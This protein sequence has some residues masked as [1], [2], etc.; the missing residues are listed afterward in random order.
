MALRLIELFLKRPEEIDRRIASRQDLPNLVPRL[1]GIALGG[2]SLYGLALSLVFNASASPFHLVPEIRWSDPSALRLMAAYDL[3]LIAACA[4]CLP[5]FYFFGLLSGVRLT[6][7][8][9]VAFAL[10]GLATAALVLVAIVPI[11]FALA[12]ALMVAGVQGLALELVLALGLALPF[13][14]GVWGVRSFFRG[15][16]LLAETLPEDRRLRRTCFLRRLAFS[17]ACCYMA[18]SPTMIYAIFQRLA[19]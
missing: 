4:I 10:E 14:A 13:V 19:A 11:H 8:Q 6:M 9:V 1:L 18:V 17:W 16:F 15:W 2:F 5:S 3:G 12:M 7:A